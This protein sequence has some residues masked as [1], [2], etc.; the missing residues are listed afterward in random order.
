MQVLYVKDHGKQLRNA[1]K[2]VREK[3]NITWESDRVKQ[4]AFEKEFNCQ[5]IMSELV[6]DRA[7]KFT[8]ESAA[9]MFLLKWS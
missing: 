5:I 8:S 9:T 6:E 4:D 1:D 3:Y 2:Y 7:V